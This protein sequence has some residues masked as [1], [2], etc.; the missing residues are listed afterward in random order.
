MPALLESLRSLKQC[1]LYR[2]KIDTDEEVVMMSLRAHV[3]ELL[4]VS[5]PSLRFRLFADYLV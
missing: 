5:S 2:C 3:E 4:I 1:P